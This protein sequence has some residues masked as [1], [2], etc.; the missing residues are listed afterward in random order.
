M[1]RLSNA[2]VKT[3][4][5]PVHQL[6]LDFV[7]HDEDNK[8]AQSAAHQ[9]IDFVI[10]NTNAKLNGLKAQFAAN[11]EA[12]KLLKNL[13]H[14]NGKASEE[15][16]EILA[17]FVGW[18]GLSSA[19]R[20][21]DNSIK[22]GWTCEVEMLE[23][24]LSPQELQAA[25]ESSLTAFYTPIEIVRAM[26]GAV[27]RMGFKGGKI[28]EPS[29]GIGSFLGAMPKNLR[30]NAAI[31]GTELDPITGNL[32]KYLYP[33]AKIQVMGFEQYSIPN[34]FFRLAIGNPP[35]GG[36][37][38]TD[39]EKTHLNGFSIHNYF[40]AKSVDALEDNGILAMVV[41]HNFLDSLRDRARDYIAERTELLLAVRLPNDVFKSAGTDV[42]VD[43][44][45]LR[46]LST[47][48]RQDR[49][50]DEITP[51]WVD[52]ATISDENGNA[53]NLNAYFV[54][55][56]DLMLGKFVAASG[57]YGSETAT[58]VADENQD[59]MQMLNE[60]LQT[61]LPENVFRLPENG[62]IES[63]I[64]QADKIPV[65]V[66]VGYFFVE[67]DLIFQRLPD[68]LG[69]MQSQLLPR[70]EKGSIPMMRVLGLIAIREALFKVR[71]LQLS[72]NVDVGELEQARKNLNVVYDNFVKKFG[73]I[74]E[75]V[76]RSIFSDDSS[77]P[78]LLALEYNFT[79]GITAA[80]AKKTGE[81]PC[82]PSATKA[83]IFTQRTQYPSIEV[84]NVA[85]AKDGLCESLATTGRLDLA[86]IVSKSGKSI[87][88][89]I[90]ELGDLIFLN[91]LTF[92]W[93]TAEIYLSGNVKKKLA[94][95][96]EMVEKNNDPA[97]LRNIA[98]LQQ[99]IP[100][101]VDASEITV[102][103][104]ATWLPEKVIGDFLSNIGVSFLSESKVSVN[105]EIGKWFISKKSIFP[106]SVETQFGTDDCG[107]ER[108]ISAALN[109]EV[110]KVYRVD[111]VS[112]N[113]NLDAEAT[114]E[115][116]QK[117][118]SVKQAFNEWIW[119][120]DTRRI[121]I[122]KI[123]ND[124]FNN[125]VY[126][127]YDGSHLNLIGKVSDD[128][129]T[130]RPS[131]KNAIWRI[132][133][134][135][136][137][138]LDHVVGAG[139]TYTM[140][141][142]A[143]ELRRMGLAH[144]PLI[145]VPNHLIE[146]WGKEFYQLY[147]NANILIAGKKDFEKQNRKQMIAKI[148][149]GDWDSVIIGHSS[150]GKIAVENC[151]K[152]D[153]IQGQIDDLM[154]AVE[155][156]KKRNNGT[157]L[158]IKEAERRIK[159]LKEKY[160]R[161]LAK[162]ADDQDNLLW[163]EIGIDALFIDE[164]HE[165]KN[166]AFVSTMTN[167]AGLG[168]QAGSQKAMDLYLKI[169]QLCEN[170]ENVRIVFATGTPISNSMA[171]MYTMQRYLDENCLRR[172]YVSTFDA[173]ARNFGEVVNDFE[174]TASGVYKLKSRLSKYV[175]MPELMRSY[176]S[177]GDV[178]T[179]DDLIASMAT[180]GLKISIPPLKGGKPENV[181]VPRSPFQ[182]TYIGEQDE[183]GNYPETSLV[184]RA[185]NLPKGKKA[186]EKGA[187]NMLK[188]MG[189][190]RKL[191]LDPRILNPNAP[192]VDYSKVNT[193][194]KRIH[195]LYC[196]WNAV[197]GTQLVFC[198]LSTPKNHLDDEKAVLADLIARMEQGDEQA[199]TEY[200]K[201]SP[202]EIDAILN[203]GSFDIYN[204]LKIKL[205]MRGI[206]ENEIAFIHEAKTDSQ[207]AELF[208]K[209]RSGR[210]RILLGSTSKMGAGTNVQERLVAL[211]HLDVAWRPSDLEQREGRILRQGNILYAADPDNF[212]VEILRYATE[213]TLDSMQWQIIE[214]KARFIAQVRKG[215]NVSRVIDDLDGEALNAA[216]MKA[217]CSGNP[218]ILEEMNVRKEIKDLETAY[219]SHFKNQNRIKQTISASKNR[220][221][222]N[223]KR[224]AEI[225]ELLSLNNPSK[226]HIQIIQNEQI[227][228]FKQGDK[229]AREEVGELLLKMSRKQTIRKIGKFNHFDLAVG[230]DSMGFGFCKIELS[231]NDAAFHIELSS[232]E[233]ASG[234]VTRIEFAIKALEKNHNDFIADNEK[235]LQ[236]IP[237]LE[238]QICDWGK[239]GELEAARNRHKEI[240]AMLSAPTT[241]KVQQQTTEAA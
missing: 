149:Y 69:E 210:V 215:K 211:H 137:T 199:A 91:P 230:I 20:N 82:N 95:A 68:V 148:A 35:F 30:A 229:N 39:T 26:W 1:A 201:Y 238:S 122:E 11:Y 70:F 177:F 179:K 145:V 125:T 144:K 136:S 92:A 28:L 3:K 240:M 101:D 220:F 222:F 152:A 173:W 93:E 146:Q 65:G 192:D 18:G 165:F 87:D 195:A 110:I 171:E 183:F 67:N 213:K 78:Q 31:Y 97:F 187:D 80:V 206:P 134:T 63:Q 239:K 22:S 174:L 236:D 61:R 188:I 66:K 47:Q 43:L 107:A 221:S 120:D 231:Y 23:E 32:A 62:E 176:L 175:N 57:I 180:M 113:R 74:N 76:N 130:L 139:K 157:S 147:P 225:K 108:I 81:V 58:L 159:S 99:V 153:F 143:M 237:R 38:I 55:N 85:S 131:Q 109:D 54:K 14:W 234:I 12:I 233:K 132:T 114:A 124:L 8:T 102:R 218:L 160:R 52:I 13:I 115:A 140:V 36:W 88:E 226:F 170:N 73:F 161:L 17:R 117:V 21:P 49:R 116:V 96:Q 83:P 172:Q 37:K 105:Q 59:T 205:M 119:Q 48:E 181:I 25:R 45:F 163:H 214:S 178:I 212:Q 241:P 182:A 216:Q 94:I 84:V 98:A 223:E 16:R 15:E 10:G 142:A 217:A 75:R 2:F 4:P 184:Y 198:D 169:K 162:E 194:A 197:K 228:H 129:I 207:K 158:S 24:L 90:A 154:F 112:G 138:L 135:Q 89:V 191:A 118:Q 151:Y 166:L 193:A 106:N 208:G 204:E 72:E 209:V 7:F 41:T 164:A 42:T 104:G 202:A 51:E 111:V 121:E 155:M 200:E 186:A 190:A 50:L 44:I 5:N 86:R 156:E 33:Q 6:M 168:N 133:Q 27:E 100:Q 128:V 141:A 40:F 224:I 56:P 127:E 227:L 46:K 232:L 60:I 203:S 196:K 167:V 64:I 150:F 71:N 235:I 53:L 79:A 219:N 29:I 123:Y 34:G 103:F 189:E 9:E 185:E 19:F 77:L 126:P